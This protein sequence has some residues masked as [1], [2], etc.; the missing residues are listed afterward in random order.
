MQNSDYK[1]PEETCWK[2]TGSDYTQWTSCK[3][4]E[5]LKLNN[6]V[7]SKKLEEFIDKSILPY[8]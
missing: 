6:K 7:L 4:C 2:V 8:S 1:S 5:F 3:E